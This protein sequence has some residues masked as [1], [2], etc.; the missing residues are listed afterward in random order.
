MRSAT[1]N[2]LPEYENT[3]TSARPP[4]AA[5]SGSGSDA[6]DS[7]GPP[8]SSGAGASFSST[9]SSAATHP[10][11]MPPPSTAMPKPN[12]PMTKVRRSNSLCLMLTLLSLP[13]FESTS[14][15]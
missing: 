15:S 8:S 14:W 4:W 6:T 2:V 9:C 12:D 13:S 5:G 11:S 1:E 3:A 10:A 7:A